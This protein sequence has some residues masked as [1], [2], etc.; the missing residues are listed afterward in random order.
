MRGKDG[1]FETKYKELR[2]YYDNCKSLKPP[3]PLFRRRCLDSNIL[4]EEAIRP[5]KFIGKSNIKTE[6]NNEWRV[7]TKCKQF[8]TRSNFYYQKNSLLSKTS[9]CKQCFWSKK[10]SKENQEFLNKRRIDQCNL[11]IWDIIHFN[12]I[13]LGK[14]WCVLGWVEKWKIASRSARGTYTIMSLTSWASKLFHP[15][16]DS[17]YY[18]KFYK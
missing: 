15:R 7:C 17:K 5:V 3:Y 18:K 2:E 12:E 6:Y 9:C 11:S 4:R 10:M 16:I 14:D 13:S 8:K 1:R